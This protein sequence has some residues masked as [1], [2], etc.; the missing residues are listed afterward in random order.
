M[1]GLPQGVR[2]IAWKG[3]MQMCRRYKH[4]VA[5]GKRTLVANTAIAREIVGFI[6]AITP[7]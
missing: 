3:Q 2:D 4:L 1:E 5:C 6:W 7:A